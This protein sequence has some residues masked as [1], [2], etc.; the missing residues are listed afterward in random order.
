MDRQVFV[1]GKTYSIVRVSSCNRGASA[2]L[3]GNE[4]IISVPSRWPGHEAERVA[5][6]LEEKAIKNLSSGRWGTREMRDIEFSTGQEFD[7][8]GR[9]FRITNPSDHERI[10][11]GITR[12]MLPEIE[13]RIK[14]L[15]EA[16]FKAEIKKISLRD[17]TTRWGSYSPKGTVNLNFRLLFAPPEILDYVI[18][19][20][21]AHS[22]YKSHGQRFWGI[23]EGIVPDHRAKRRWLKENGHRL[24]PGLKLTGPK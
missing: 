9:R 16:H 24:G 3:R 8:L 1:S 15:N 11:K 14:S 13:R 7:I 21:L 10:R 18:I 22:R 17:N 23:V 20:E 19:H 2:R 4:I 12:R 6:S 5:R